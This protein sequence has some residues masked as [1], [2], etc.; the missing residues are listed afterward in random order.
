MAGIGWV[1]FRAHCIDG[2]VQVVL[3]DRTTGVTLQEDF[4]SRCLICPLTG[5]RVGIDQVLEKYDEAHEAALILVD[6]LRFAQGI[7]NGGG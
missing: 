4:E 6:T 1:E 3:V 5:H 2:Q 7:P